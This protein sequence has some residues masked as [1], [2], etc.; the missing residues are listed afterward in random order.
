MDKETIALAL[1]SKNSNLLSY[2]S[3]GSFKVLYIE[4]LHNCTCH[5][6]KNVILKCGDSL[7]IGCV[8]EIRWKSTFYNKS[9]NEFTKTVDAFC[10]PYDKYNIDNIFLKCPKCL[11]FSAIGKYKSILDYLEF[12]CGCK[13]KNKFNLLS[14]MF[15]QTGDDIKTKSNTLF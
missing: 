5:K 7:C 2:V 1:S 6:K 8:A 12:H 4:Y 9:E 14:S 10:N 3:A 15:L 11:S 13:F